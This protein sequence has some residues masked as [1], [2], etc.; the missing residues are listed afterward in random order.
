MLDEFASVLVELVSLPLS[1]CVIPTP[2][3]IPTPT[4]DSLLMLS[5]ALSEALSGAVSEV[6]SEAASEVV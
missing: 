3:V 6:L 2:N 4:K 5:G 1:A